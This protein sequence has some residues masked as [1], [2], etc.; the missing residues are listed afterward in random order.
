MKARTILAAAMTALVFSCS[1]KP[2]ED[3]KLEP[4]YQPENRIWY[5]GQILD[6]K[7]AVHKT[8]N[9]AHTFYLSPTSGE[10]DADEMESKGNCLKINIGSLAG[11][12]DSFGIS[13]RD[14]S[15]DQSNAAAAR[16]FSFDLD[17]KDGELS[18]YLW[19]A[20]QGGK[21][22]VAA[23]SGPA[24]ESY[25]E[26][27]HLS[28]QFMVGS[29]VTTIS[30]V[31][32]WRT[33]GESRTYSLY[34]TTGITTPGS[35]KKAE[36]EITIPE[37]CYGR[38]IELSG[39]ENIIVRQNGEEIANGGI[40]GTFFA[41]TGRLGADLGLSID[42]VAGGKQIRVEYSGNTSAGYYSTD[43]FEFGSNGSTVSCH[44]GKMFGHSSTGS[45]TLAF[46]YPERE[47]ARPEDLVV[48]GSE[49]YAVRFTIAS[50]QIGSEIELGPGSA[51]AAIFFYDYATATTY[52][53]KKEEIVS[54]SIL[55]LDNMP[56]GKMFIRVS[57]TLIDGRSLASEYFGEVTMV[58]EDFDIAPVLPEASTII[59]T[60]KDENE[61]LNLEVISLQI[62]K[63]N[64]Y[65][66]NFGETVSP[67]Y[68]LYFVNEKSAEDPHNDSCTPQLVIQDNAFGLGKTGIPEGCFWH[69]AYSYYAG[70]TLL[71]YSSYG[72][73]Y[74]SFGY[75][76]SSA[77][78]DAVW[79]DDKSL[80]IIFSFKDEISNSWGSVS[81]T[82]NN[83]AIE[84]HG[85]AALYKGSQDNLLTESDVN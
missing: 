72:S 26:P 21:E 17:F 42:I 31:L 25:K 14:L 56:D 53:M 43:K 15:I 35:G 5:C 18:L 3:N 33:A 67:V 20:D 85:K 4:S 63:T 60:D 9:G 49:A 24:L 79:N 64:S 55:T 61:L 84:W 45:L 27:V 59:V 76:P 73:Q 34:S 10:T 70:D 41:S 2:E 23:Y 38:Q 40:T 7:S 75:C 51:A 29:E 77:V 62:R 50:N 54:G 47:L 28:N 11:Y 68:V 22:L 58:E 71:Q 48:E 12:K 82:K 65:R 32:D 13:Y 66:S 74:N 16:A 46:G 6:I 30:S 80:D 83:I 37:E 52:S 78:L 1:E 69:F 44:L 81:G 36:L 57:L 8:E 39:E 19:I